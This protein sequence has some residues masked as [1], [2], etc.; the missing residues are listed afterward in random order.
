MLFFVLSACSQVQELILEQIDDFEEIGLPIEEDAES[1]PIISEEHALDERAMLEKGLA[2]QSTLHKLGFMTDEFPIA[3][4]H[5]AYYPLE[6]TFGYSSMYRIPGA[7]TF[8]KFEAGTSFGASLYEDML[9]HIVEPKKIDHDTME[10]MYGKY[11]DETDGD[12]YVLAKDKGLSYVLHIG[13][14][15]EG[16]TEKVVA[17][18]GSTLRSESDGAYDPFYKRFALDLE[19]LHFPKINQ[20]RA[21]V[22]D[23]NV[24]YWEADERSAISLTYMLSEQDTISYMIQDIKSDISSEYKMVDEFLIKDNIEV[25][26]YEFDGNKQRALFH[27]QLDHYDYTIETDLENKAILQNEEI[28]QIIASSLEDDRGFEH[29]ELFAGVNKK[30]NRTKAEKKLTTSL[31]KLHQAE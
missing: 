28:H 13:D 30:P 1:L 15:A 11:I 19:K 20:K 22:H 14:E 3:H 21:V 8:F 16:F 18:I 7:Q 5:I 6:E 26:Q 24:Y 27:W 4:T 31:K 12:Y 9:D 29:T 25:T 17:D 2:E 23:T 10:T